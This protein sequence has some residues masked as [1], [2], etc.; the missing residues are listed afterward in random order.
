MTDKSKRTIENL[1]KVEKRPSLN[2]NNNEKRPSLAQYKTMKKSKGGTLRKKNSFYFKPEYTA[3]L[4]TGE[5][6]I[7][8]MAKQRMEKE[9]TLRKKQGGKFKSIYGT[10]TRNPSIYQEGTLEHK[11]TS[12]M[13]L[14]YHDFHKD[15]AD[16]EARDREK[17]KK[18]QDEEYY[19]LMKTE[20]ASSKYKEKCMKKA[21]EDY[22]KF[23]DTAEK[24]LDD[25][26]K[27]FGVDDNSLKSLE[28]R[29]RE[30]IKHNAQK[31]KEEESKKKNEAASTATAVKKKEEPI[32]KPEKTVGPTEGEKQEP[33]S[34][35]K[36]PPP[37]VI[38]PAEPVEASKTAE[39]EAVKKEI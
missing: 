25:I 10:L 20:K 5:T 29:I 15:F 24:E 35:S 3:D 28:K 12:M 14:A 6:D 27:Q 26:E 7:R 1:K 19:L 16:A 39:A 36:A 11:L 30:T 37:A 4:N 32:V 18:Q 21:K 17:M 34:V 31:S 13:D 9:K 33:P 38:A 8:K 23:Y 2:L 22:G